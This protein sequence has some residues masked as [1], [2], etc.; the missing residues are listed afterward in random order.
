M[1]CPLNDGMEV[2]SQND[3]SVKIM[4]VNYAGSILTDRFNKKL[5]KC[6]G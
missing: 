4:V 6:F 5:K 2:N 3:N 1:L